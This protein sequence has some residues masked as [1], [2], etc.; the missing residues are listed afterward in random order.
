MK[1]ADGIARA[2]LLGGTG[3]HLCARASCDCIAELTTIIEQA[4]VNGR[5]AERWRLT[6]LRLAKPRIAEALEETRQATRR[7]A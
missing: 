2:F 4:R 7:R 3:V 6:Q 1:P 5:D